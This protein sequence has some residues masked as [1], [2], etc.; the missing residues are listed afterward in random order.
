MGAALLAASVIVPAFHI[1]PAVPLTMQIVALCLVSFLFGARAAAAGTAL[2]VLLGVIGLPIFAGFKSGAAVVVGPTGGY[3]LGYIAA[4]AVMGA[5]AAR[6]HGALARRRTGAA[7]AVLLGAGVAGV[8]VI[9]LCGVIGLIAVAGF[10][11]PKALGVTAAFILPDLLKVVFAAVIALAVL[12]AFR[13]QLVA[14][15]SA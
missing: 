1:T 9:H 2:Y 11:L 8:A 5:L 4:A 13:R 7:L 12:S 6:S 15:R 14:P 3:L 10:S